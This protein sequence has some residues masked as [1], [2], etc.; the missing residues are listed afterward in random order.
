[1]QL[2]RIIISTLVTL[3]VVAIYV[4]PVSAKHNDGR[5]YKITITNLTAGQPFT[6]PVLVTHS[7][8]TGIFTLGAEASAEIQ[9][10]AEN[11]NPGPLLAALGVD[12]EVHDVVAGSAPLVPANNP[13]GTMFESSATFMITTRGK[14]DRLSFASMLIC[15][16][17]G[18]TG[19]DG[20]KLSRKKKTVFSV[21]YDARTETNTE[22]FADMVPPCQG[23]IGVS[24]DDAGTGMTNPL[25]AEDGVVIP[26]V[27][28][29][30][31]VDLHREVH[32]WSDPV[33]KI[34]IERM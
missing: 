23:L 6:P 5:T 34:V 8:K 12:A 19:L 21:A 27:G 11:G 3:S 30:G 13:G 14:A 7:S 9:A 4:A 31:G 22:D 1:M 15:T 29:T 18:F 17:D 16:N 25:L 32:D 10:I 33:A 2:K 24:S 28:I 20:I 26:H